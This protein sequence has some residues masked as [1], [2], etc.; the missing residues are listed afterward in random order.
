ME[1]L[2]IFET[3]GSRM[4]RIE[5]IHSQFLADALCTSLND[6]RSLFDGF[7]KLAA[8]PD[9]PVPKRANV[10]TEQP[11]GNRR[12][13]DLWIKDVEGRRILG[14]EVKTTSA[15]AN[16]GQLE[17]YEDGLARKHPD[18]DVAIAYLTPFNL[19]RAGEAADRLPTVKMFQAFANEST[20]N[21]QHVSWLDVADISWDGRGIWRD[22]Q[23][24]VRDKISPD[25]KLSSG[26]VR[27]RTFTNFFSDEAVGAFWEAL[28]ELQVVPTETGA[29]VELDRLAASPRALARAFEI[30]IEDGD[31]VSHGN[32]SDKFPLNLRERFRQPPHGAVHLELFELADR[33]PNVWIEGKRDYAV[34][35]AHKRHSSG[36]SLVR[37]VDPGMLKIGEPR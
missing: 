8:P 12:R 21:G 7:W 18:H 26:I 25:T 3:I 31:N 9:W 19:K 4:S 29:T 28:A 22:H 17:A 10:K 33:F 11:A 34:R 23:A 13:I 30:L 5:P 20:R 36:V 1:K 6:D 27:N 37:S 35:V 2:N 32:R 24:Y 15:S 16:A 14:V